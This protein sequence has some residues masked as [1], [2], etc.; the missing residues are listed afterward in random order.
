MKISII[1][2]NL[3]ALLLLTAF[4][5]SKDEFMEIMVGPP[6]DIQLK[7][8]I[9]G[10]DSGE[11][12]VFPE[13]MNASYFDIYYGDVSGETPER[14]P[15]GEAGKHTYAEGQ[16]TMRAV[17]YSLSGETAEITQ[18]VNIQF[19]A[20]ENLQVEVTID[21]VNTNVITVTPTADNATLFEIYFGDAEE[22]EPTNIMAGESIQHT[23]AETGTYTLRVVARSASSTTLEYTEELNIVKP[24]VQLTLPIDFENPE[25]SY[26]FVSFGGAE[27]SL[28]DNPDPSGENTSAKVG[29]LFKTAGAEVWA[30]GLLQLPNPIDFNAGDQFSVKVWSPKSGMTVRLKVENESDPNIFYELDATTTVTN[31]WE[32]L[33][34]DFSGIDKSEAYHKVVIFMDFGNRG[35]DSEYFFDDFVLSGGIQ[36]FSLPINFEADNVDYTFV[37]FGNVT[38]SR[39]DNPDPSG[40]NTSAKVAALNKPGN[41]ETWGGTF[42]QLGS[43]I[44][45]AANDQLTAKVW[46]PKSSIV[47]KMK[48]ENSADPNINYEVDVTNTVSNGWEQLVYD[49]SGIDKSKEYDRVVIFFDFGA[50]GDGSDYYFD[51][52]GQL[53]TGLTLPLN[54][55]SDALEYAFTDFGNITAGRID[56]PDPSGLNTSAKVGTL[57]KPGN[58]ETW[59]GTFLTLA[60]PMDFDAADQFSVKV[61]SPKSGIVVKLKVENSA[62]PNINYEIDVTNTMSNTWEELIYDFSGIDKSQEYD[63][64]VIF[65]DFG[66]NG[67][68][69]DYYFDDIQLVA[70]DSGPV[71]NI[72][73]LPLNFESETLSYSFTAF[74]NVSAAVIANPDPS[75][76][77]TS[78][79]VARQ[80][81]AVGAET[82][83]G[84]FIQLPDPIDFSTMTTMQFKAWSPKSGI[85]VLLK[86]ENATNGNTFH[87][88]QVVNTKANEWELLTFDMS[89]IDKTKTYHKVV[90]FFDFGVNGDGSEYFYDDIELK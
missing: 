27:L 82:W 76:I 57:N 11:L 55:E 79:N 85:N 40:L 36:S 49:F 64:V 86:L 89:A 6:S 1:R 75:G 25:I 46:S 74:G 18:A 83:G 10:D 7:F 90:I 47:V 14:V 4:A 39:I 16:Y 31:Q 22:E 26:A 2:I 13:A 33:S 52:I 88:V 44:D 50:N 69:S 45:F 60:G 34:F 77:N 78:A 80:T 68:G 53:E 41:A 56:N 23:Y 72:L 59:G 70:G 3:Y 19:T 66:A 87:E 29:R 15:V 62:D 67:D 17:A 35:D 71:E 20:P 84:A 54:F 9:A 48:V 43:P 37:D 28:V 21:P 81:K 32:T 73:A 58:A 51:E 61:W 12:T 63:R 65:F 42:M 5:C 8:S 38:T 24:L 30:G